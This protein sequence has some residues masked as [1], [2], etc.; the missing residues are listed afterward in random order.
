MER[1][2]ESIPNHHHQAEN[3]ELNEQ[4]DIFQNNSNHHHQHQHQQ[5]Q[6]HEQQQQQHHPHHHHHH[7]EHQEH[8]HHHPHL[9]TIPVHE[10]H[11][12]QQ[13]QQHQQ[14]QTTTTT[15]LPTSPV[16]TSRER[17]QLTAGAAALTLRLPPS[18]T[19]PSLPLPSSIDTNAIIAF[20]RAEAKQAEERARSLREYADKLAAGEAG[21]PDHELAPL[22]ENGVPKYK[23]K[24]R[25]RKPKKRKRMRNPNA[26]KRKHTAYTLYVQE[27]Y[28]QLKSQFPQPQY[29]SKDIIGMVAKNWKSVSSEDK[30]VWKERAKQES[31]NDDDLMH[32]GEIDVDIGVD[33]DGDGDGDG[34]D[35]GPERGHEVHEHH[36]HTRVHEH[37]HA[38]AHAHVHVHRLSEGDVMGGNVMDAVHEGHDD[39]REEEEREEVEHEHVQEVVQHLVVGGAENGSGNGH[40]HGHGNTALSVVETGADMVVMQAGARVNAGEQG[41]DVITIQGE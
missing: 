21:T 14:H 22:D 11:H 8:H 24:K 32:S 34:D 15:T 38:H 25:G 19:S 13:H 7:Q 40:G 6:H 28:P 5:Q 18:S 17:S 10:D 4:G 36:P 26:P 16:A 30:E 9:A 29:Q 2:E 27:M 20:L 37:T 31:A 35:D 23:G 12:H 41:E 33:G 3:Q 1:N 39:D